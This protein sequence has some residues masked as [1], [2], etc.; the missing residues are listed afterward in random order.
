MVRA[1]HIH[2]RPETAIP[3]VAVVSKIGSHIGVRTVALDEH[4][5]LVVPESRR[6]QP[7]GAFSLVYVVAP[8]KLMDDLL[9]RAR[10]VEALLIEEVVETDPYAGQGAPD[11]VH[12]PAGRESSDLA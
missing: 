2:G 8:H 11:I 5:V 3:L 7:Q 4:P 12:T 1:E 6:C 10:L 9:Y